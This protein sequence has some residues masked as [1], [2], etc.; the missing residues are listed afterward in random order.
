MS[1]D[2]IAASL[3]R[4]A[5]SIDKAAMG[6]DYHMGPLE[7]I[8]VKQGEMS[9]RIDKVTEGLQAIAESIDGLAATVNSLTIAVTNR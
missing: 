6:T 2:N 3:N 5:H 4:V 9:E 7:R 8:A 1:T